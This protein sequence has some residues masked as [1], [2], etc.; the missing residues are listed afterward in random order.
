[1]NSNPLLGPQIAAVPGRIELRIVARDFVA[2][3]IHLGAA[4]GTGLIRKVQTAGRQIQAAVETRVPT[5]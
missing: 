5:A 4:L 2:V 3:E 1:M